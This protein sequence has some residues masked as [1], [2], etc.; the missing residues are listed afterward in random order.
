M[1]KRNSLAES[2]NVL[3]FIVEMLGLLAMT[4]M[5]IQGF[6]I[7]NNWGGLGSLVSSL[8]QLVIQ[9]HAEFAVVLYI[10]LAGHVSLAILHVAS[11]DTVFL[12]ILP[13]LRKQ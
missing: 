5:A 4:A 10:Y 7:W 11:G 2:S 8:S 3:L 6:I 12:R 1:V 9:V 13:E